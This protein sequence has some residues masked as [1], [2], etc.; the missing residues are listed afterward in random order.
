MHA[1]FTLS[2]SFP[3]WLALSLPLSRRSLVC[4]RVGRVPH[5]LQRGA[6][7]VAGALVDAQAQAEDSSR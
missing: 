4:Y 7:E 5:S 3:L 6:E 1:R 2:L